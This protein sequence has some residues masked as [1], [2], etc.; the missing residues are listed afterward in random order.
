MYNIFRTEYEA[1]QIKQTCIL[2]QKIITRLA[3]LI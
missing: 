3:F 1:Y 2:Y